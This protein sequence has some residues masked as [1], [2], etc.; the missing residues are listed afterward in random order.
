MTPP[1]WKHPKNT[2]IITRPY[3][4]EQQVHETTGRPDTFKAHSQMAR[5]ITLPFMP[6]PHS[7]TKPQLAACD[8]SVSSSALVRT[9]FHLPFGLA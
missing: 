3:N 6:S 4:T 1:N 8:S 7:T 5:T 9:D 2:G